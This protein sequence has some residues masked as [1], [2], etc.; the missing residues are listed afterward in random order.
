MKNPIV[1]IKMYDGGVIKAEL[2]PDIAPTD[3]R[4]WR[5]L[6]VLHPYNAV[7]NSVTVAVRR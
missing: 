2:Y 5:P 4:G 3:L 7:V 6:A 1:T